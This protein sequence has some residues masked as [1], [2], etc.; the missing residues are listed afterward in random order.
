MAGLKEPSEDKKET[1]KRIFVNMETPT[2][3]WTQQQKLAQALLL[4]DEALDGFFD[5]GGNEQINA[6][7]FN[8]KVLVRTGWD[9]IWEYCTKH[10]LGK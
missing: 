7:E 8:E 6:K 10:R 5:L 4:V 1:L 3:T 9:I 2:L